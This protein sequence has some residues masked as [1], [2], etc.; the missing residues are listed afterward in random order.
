MRKIRMTLAGLLLSAA[1]AFG[2]IS[3]GGGNAVAIGFPSDLIPAVSQFSITEP[4][5]SSG[6]LFYNAYTRTGA[7]TGTS[8]PQ[9]ANPAADLVRSLGRTITATVGYSS[10]YFYLGGG[11]VHFVVPIWGSTTTPD[12]LSNHT[13]SELRSLLGGTGATKSTDFNRNNR[14]VLTGTVRVV[15]FP[16]SGGKVTIAQYHADTTTTPATASG[17]TFMLLSVDQAGNLASSITKKDQSGT[18]NTTVLTPTSVLGKRISFS[19]RYDTDNIIHWSVSID[20]GAAVLTDQAVEA[21][22]NGAN[23]YAKAG[24][25]HSTD[26]LCAAEP[27]YSNAVGNGGLLS[28]RFTDYIETAWSA[29]TLTLLNP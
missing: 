29:L 22:W 23:I 15:K 14:P 21:A 2:Y 26:V 17:D 18:F 16:A 7:C 27:D 9:T 6:E 19:A 20:G 25:Y 10:P 8:A 3:L 28:A 4:V 11:E 12:T 5:N 24:A 13:R 1:P